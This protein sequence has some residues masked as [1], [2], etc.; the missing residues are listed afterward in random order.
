M[1]IRKN[2]FLQKILQP[3]KINFLNLNKFSRMYAIVRKWKFY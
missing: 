1:I 2:K 3:V